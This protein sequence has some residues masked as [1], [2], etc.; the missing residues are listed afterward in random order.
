MQYRTE[1]NPYEI[2]PEHR[3]KRYVVGRDRVQGGTVQRW[4]FTCPK[5]AKEH[6][7]LVATYAN[8]YSVWLSDCLSR[9]HLIQR[10]IK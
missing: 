6:L 3:G 2:A 9:K 1:Q 8:T 7:E 10:R 4:M 5:Q